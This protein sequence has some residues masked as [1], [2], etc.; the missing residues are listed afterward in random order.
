MYASDPQIFTI[1]PV[2]N[3]AD[4]T[5]PEREDRRKGHAVRIVHLEHGDAMVLAYI[6]YGDA[7]LRTSSVIEAVYTD[8]GRLRVTTRNTVYTFRKVAA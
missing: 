8:D 4:D 3:R 1:E 6:D 2:R 5:H 7:L